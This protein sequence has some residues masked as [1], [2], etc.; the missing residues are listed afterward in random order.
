MG[1]IGEFHPIPKAS[2]LK[3]N[4]RTPKRK[5]RGKFSP[6]TITAILERDGYACVSCHRSTMIENTPHHV[7][8]KSQGG[9]GIKRNGVTICRM[10]HDWA[11]GK[12]TGPHGEPEKDGRKFFENWV[13]QHLDENG[14]LIVG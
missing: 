4:R 13:D 1:M 9:Q 6:D 3:H 2:Q 8:F 10:C 14:D 5:D 7:I 12:T 11:H